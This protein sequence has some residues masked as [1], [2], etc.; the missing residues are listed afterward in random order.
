MTTLVTGAAG[1]IGYHVSERLLARGDRVIG[2]DNVNDYYSVAAEAR[3][4]RRARAAATTASSSSRSISPTRRRLRRALDGREFDRIVHLGAQ[5]GVRYSIENPHAYVQSNLVGHLN[6]LELARAPP[7]EPS[8]LRLLLVGLWR[9]R[10]A[11]RSG[12]R[13]GSIIR[14]RSTP[15][16]R[17]PTS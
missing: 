5:A 13:T 3:P 16:P 8:R 17:R 10:D 9:Q 6:M 2:I 12:S 4:A 14:S 11:C 1:F 7:L 15:R